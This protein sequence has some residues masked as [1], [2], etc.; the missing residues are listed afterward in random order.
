MVDK[1]FWI[2]PSNSAVN[3]EN[4]ST[5]CVT[6]KHITCNNALENDLQRRK[7]LLVMHKCSIC[8]P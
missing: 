5:T 8:N 2:Q 1:Y 6:Y 4:E 7:A 3:I